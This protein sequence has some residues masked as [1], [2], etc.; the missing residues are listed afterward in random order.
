MGIN[1]VKM[2][3]VGKDE[4][5]SS[6]AGMIDQ[7]I[8]PWVEDIEEDGYPV[9]EDYEA[10]Q[11]STYFL[12]RQGELIYQFN[13]TTLNPDNANDYSYFINLI[14]DFRSNNGPDVLRVSEEYASIQSAI[15]DA[16]NGDLI[17]VEPG[18]YNEQIDFLGK[19]ISLVSLP[20]SGYEDNNIGIVT[21]DGGGQGPVV[22]INS[23]EDQSSILLGFR[24]RNGYSQ[25]YGG[26]ILI[27]NSS[28]TIDRNIITDNTSGSC[29]GGGGG[30][31]ILGSS[32]PH[33]FGNRIYNNIV[34]GDCDCICYFGGGIYV[35]SLSLPVVGGSYT[36]GNILYDNYADL[37]NELFR[38][39]SSESVNATQI[40]AHHNFFKDCPP[41]SFNVYPVADWDLSNCHEI[42]YV[43]YDPIIPS[44]NFH[45]SPVYPNPFNPI[46]TIPISII[47][48]GVLDVSIYD[49]RGNLVEKWNT[50]I[51]T[52]NHNLTWDARNQP[53][54]IYFIK[55]NFN[56]FYESQKAI[57]IK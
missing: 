9:W 45:I 49:L 51:T 57:L 27:E 44:N 41:D 35:D 39:M 32:Y 19:N 6:L 50:F 26:G 23:G 1:D 13:I 18:I 16:N 36:L 10:V 15:I 8:L 37:G 46:T 21:L 42:E 20:F 31:A 4:Y 30:I 2:I 12:N 11:R 7:N 43:K 34:S 54:G 29:G 24:I 53:S 25:N 52:G 5:N 56:E 55:A 17:L 40:Y 3:G 22:T 33:L 28:P 48:S 38:N 14:L 47:E